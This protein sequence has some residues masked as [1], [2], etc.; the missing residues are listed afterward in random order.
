MLNTADVAYL[1]TGDTLSGCGIAYVNTITLPFGLGSHAC[2]R[3]GYTFGHE[4]GHIL[5]AQHNAEVPT[6]N[7][8]FSYG[9]GYLILP[10]GPTTFSGYRTIMA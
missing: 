8:F 6:T 10:P 5:G 1:L 2:S 3:G 9:L 7:P 4:V